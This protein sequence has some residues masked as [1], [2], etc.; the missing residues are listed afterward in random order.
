MKSSTKVQPATAVKDEIG[1]R[2]FPKF[3]EVLGSEE[4]APLLA[5]IE[6]TCRELNEALQAGSE[7]DK[8]RAKLAIT[9]YGRSVDL[10]RLLTEI[11]DR[12]AQQK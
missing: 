9:A 4:P 3:E 6:K 10:L 1:W 7:A 2:Q 11:R 5:K 8:T 12:S